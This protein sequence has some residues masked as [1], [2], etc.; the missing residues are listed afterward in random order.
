MNPE[1]VPEPADASESPAPARPSLDPAEEEALFQHLRRYRAREDRRR[2]GRSVLAA[3]TVLAGATG[4]VLVGL[5]P[6]TRPDAPPPEIAAPVRP[7]TTTDAHEAPRVEAGAEPRTP[8]AVP[9]VEAR[10]EPEPPHVAPVAEPPP[11]RIERSAARPSPE[12][13][14]PPVPATVAT[15]APDPPQDVAA[16]PPAPAPPAPATPREQTAPVAVPP[17]P[18]P[19]RTT[20]R[21]ATPVRYQPRE[22]LAVVRA[23]DTKERVFDRFATTFEERNGA[24]L[25][26]DGMRWRASGRSP[27]H[28][29][30]EVADVVLADGGGERVHWFLFGDGQLLAW[31]QPEEWPA[32]AR[33]HEVESD[34]RPAAA[35]VTP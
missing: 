7:A 4:L 33:R 21:D 5:G 35:L 20:A 24:V 32:A 22:R 6:W 27:H 28:A 18:A 8:H 34:Y 29:Q 31:G 19:G 23:G 30:V 15:A 2:R 3:A 13:A 12:P 1:Q 14:A 9:R 26:I 16:P 11:L 17:A 25:R 10:A